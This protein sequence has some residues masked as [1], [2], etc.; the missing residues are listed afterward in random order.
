MLPG[1]VEEHDRIGQRL[2]GGFERVLGAHDFA[3][4]RPPELGQILGHLI[5]RR[6]Q[7]AKLVARRDL[8]PLG[9][10]PFADRVRAARQPPERADHRARQMPGHRDRDPERRQRDQ[11]H[12]PAG[13]AGLVP[14]PPRRV[15]ARTRNADRGSPWSAP[16]ARRS[17]GIRLLVILHERFGVRTPR[18]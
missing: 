9:E 7:L 15:R 11:Q 4:V 5:E 1:G 3:D 10:P 6:R 2:Q 8:D 17:T 16:T 12:R 14:A 13:G 18:R